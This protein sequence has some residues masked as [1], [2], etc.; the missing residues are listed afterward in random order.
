[1]STPAKQYDLD[2]L[3]WHN[4]ISSWKC[5]DKV[6]IEMCKHDAD[7]SDWDPAFKTSANCSSGH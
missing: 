3:G 1:M 4:D 5:G 6:K 2:Q 7:V